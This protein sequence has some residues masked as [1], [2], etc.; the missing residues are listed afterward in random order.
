MR[1]V[2]AVREPE[3]GEDALRV[4]NPP[5]RLEHRDLVATHPEF[6]GHPKTNAASHQDAL[7]LAA[8]RLMW[9]PEV[10]RLALAV[11]ESMALD[12]V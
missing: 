6:D 9:L 10:E 3:L 4:C 12:V 11:R 8:R 7:A 1:P 5:P 2:D